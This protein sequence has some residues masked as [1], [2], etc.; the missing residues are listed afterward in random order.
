MT[1]ASVYSLP[2]YAL[3][4]ECSKDP[5]AHSLDRVI[6]LIARG[7]NPNA[8]T[9]LQHTP[10]TLAANRGYTETVR[11]L[12]AAGADINAKSHGGY[13]AL[14]EAAIHGKTA[15]A[16]TLLRAGADP[17][18]VDDQGETALI[19]AANWSRPEL[20][21]ILVAGGADINASGKYGTALHAAA[22][23]GDRGMLG[24]LLQNGARQDLPDS[25]GKFP[26]DWARAAG[27]ADAVSFL[28]KERD[29]RM[30]REF[31]AAFAAGT[32][33]SARLLRP[34]KIRKP[35]P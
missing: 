7:A 25:E 1:E 31:Q 13:T 9:R 19:K 29:E 3:L 35:Q 34:L 22:K 6:D 21:P 24:F 27:H 28:Q 16:Q 18:S 33:N 11:V 14:L 23:H 15:M 30:K 32:E 5:A 4:D 12:V 20:L 2:D 10:L 17:D 26:I 8:R